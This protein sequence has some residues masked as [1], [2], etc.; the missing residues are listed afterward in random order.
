[1]QNREEE[2]F[3]EKEVVYLFPSRDVILKELIY[4]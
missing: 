3:M 4:D 2:M 1:M